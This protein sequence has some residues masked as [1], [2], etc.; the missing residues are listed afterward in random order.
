MP[1]DQLESRATAR[2]VELD[3]ATRSDAQGADRFGIVT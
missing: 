2:D 1:L 3:L